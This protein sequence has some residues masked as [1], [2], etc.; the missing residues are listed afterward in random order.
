MMVLKGEP[1]PYKIFFFSFLWLIFQPKFVSANN[2]SLE[3]FNIYSI[4][5]TSNTIT[6][7]VDAKQDNSWRNS[8]NY[9][10]IWVFLKYSTDAGVSWRHGSMGGN[11]KNPPGFFAPKDF[12]LIVPQDERGFFLQRVDLKSGHIEARDV[13]F[14]W[15]YG[16]DGLS[17]EVALSPQTINSIFGIEMVYIPE[18]PFYAGDGN[19]S[20]E[21]R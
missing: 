17:D 15:D 7:T 20:S 5:K 19:S 8:L 18:G 3:N 1:V 10:A 14:I 9:D 6:F 2:I 21:Y 11:G 13:H 16:Q 4:D 12:E